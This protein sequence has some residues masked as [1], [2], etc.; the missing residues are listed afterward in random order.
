MARYVIVF[1][2]GDA[3]I[4]AVAEAL[5][6]ALTRERHHVDVVD[7]G[8]A[9]AGRA[10]AGAD[11]AVIVACVRGGR[12]GSRLARFTAREAEALAA[13]PSALVV[14]CG[15]DPDEPNL[16][17]SDAG[18]VPAPATGR[19]LHLDQVLA[20]TTWR[21]DVVELLPGRRWPSRLARLRQ[22]LAAYL[23]APA[24]RGDA[25][26]DTTDS[27][28]LRRIATS[29]AD[30]FPRVGVATRAPRGNRER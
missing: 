11:A 13:R 23:A 10:L 25:A 17:A 30:W 9:S 16:N 20:A 29:V 7:A 21:P 12:I 27:A 5:G 24:A 6:R 19:P 14:A 22:R 4:H 2:G 26:G 15:R 18:A 3:Q 8:G 28:E 1:A